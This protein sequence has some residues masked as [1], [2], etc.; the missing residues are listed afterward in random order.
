MDIDR[1]MRSKKTLGCNSL[2]WLPSEETCH[3]KNNWCVNA[4]PNAEARSARLDK[5]ITCSTVQ[6]PSLYNC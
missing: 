1:L 5:E 2:T 3:L 4:E 6:N